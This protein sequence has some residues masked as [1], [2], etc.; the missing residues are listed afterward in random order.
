[1]NAS[2]NGFMWAKLRYVYRFE[3]WSGFDIGLGYGANREF[4]DH[5]C[6]VTVNGLIFNPRPIC[7]L[8]TGENSSSGYLMVA[9]VE[10]TSI[11]IGDSIEVEIPKVKLYCPTDGS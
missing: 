10:T 4:V 5:P 9:G 6:K 3:F 7:T 11:S 2:W 8:N 1:M